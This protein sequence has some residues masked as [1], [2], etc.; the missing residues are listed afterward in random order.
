MS[1]RGKHNVPMVL[2]LQSIAD[3]EAQ[4]TAGVFSRDAYAARMFDA[5]SF[6]SLSTEQKR[7]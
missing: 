7:T 4:E 1:L 3:R 5:P 6:A 2:C